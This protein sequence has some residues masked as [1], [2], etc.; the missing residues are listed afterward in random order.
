MRICKIIKR[1]KSL[2]LQS[3]GAQYIFFGGL[4]FFRQKSYCMGK[5]Y[6]L[7]KS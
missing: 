5:I 3:K 4:E 6:F 2:S 7:R 1:L